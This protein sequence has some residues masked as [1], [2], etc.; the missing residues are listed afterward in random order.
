MSVVVLMMAFLLGYYTVSIKGKLNNQNPFKTFLSAILPSAVV[1]VMAWV[2][3]K[4][5]EAKVVKNG[6]TDPSSVSCDANNKNKGK[7]LESL[8]KNNV[9]TTESN[10]QIQELNNPSPELKHSSYLY[11]Y[12]L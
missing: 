2:I 9:H 4:T 11:R 7:L 3:Q 10:D 5:K 6:K 1:A 12:L 8:R